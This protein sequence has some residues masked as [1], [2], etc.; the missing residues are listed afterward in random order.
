VRDDV[1]H[2]IVGPDAASY[3]A[4]LGALVDA[5]LLGGKR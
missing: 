5:P 1:V 3:A 2:V 4:A